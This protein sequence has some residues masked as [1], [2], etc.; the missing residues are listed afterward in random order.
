MLKSARALF[1]PRIV[2]QILKQLFERVAH[3]NR[4][5]SSLSER[6]N[7]FVHRT[8]GWLALAP[9]EG[10]SRSLFQAVLLASFKRYYG[11]NF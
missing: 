11:D 2:F 3:N 9:R 8:D 5:F 6:S 10:V 4:V 1:D 7:S